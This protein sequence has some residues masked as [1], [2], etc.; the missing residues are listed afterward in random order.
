MLKDRSTDRE[1]IDDPSDRRAP[2]KA[3]CHTRL[4]TASSCSQSFPRELKRRI[5]YHRR[6]SATTDILRPSRTSPTDPRPSHSHP[7]SPFLRGLCCFVPFPLPPVCTPPSSPALRPCRARP[8][9]FVG[10]SLPASTPQPLAARGTTP[11]QQHTVNRP[12]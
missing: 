3:A 9:L 2:T 8:V 1:R 7:V 12:Y 6:Y 4:R 11:R 10:R 5:C